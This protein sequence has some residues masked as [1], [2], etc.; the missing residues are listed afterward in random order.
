MI[1]RFKNTSADLCGQGLSNRRKD[2]FS[3]QY[4]RYFFAFFRRARSAIFSAFFL[5][6]FPRGAC[7]A[8]L[9]CFALALTRLKNANNA[10]NACS[11]GKKSLQGRFNDGK[12]FPEVQIAVD[13]IDCTVNTRVAYVLVVKDDLQ[14]LVYFLRLTITGY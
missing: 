2:K 4:R 3:L 1:F 6:A 8:L 12:T 10:N 9:A 13:G 14:F 7:L 11:A 5:C